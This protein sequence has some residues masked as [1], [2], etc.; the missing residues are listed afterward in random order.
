M[1]MARHLERSRR[2]MRAVRSITLS[3][4]SGSSS[5]PRALG[6]LVT[7]ARC[8][9]SDTLYDELV[10][11]LTVACA[12]I[13]CRSVRCDVIPTLLDA[14]RANRNNSIVLQPIESLDGPLNAGR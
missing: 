5:L 11:M 13:S 9:L 8:V 10:T 7:D 1:A 2:A 4:S 14:D 12:D 3:R 6:R